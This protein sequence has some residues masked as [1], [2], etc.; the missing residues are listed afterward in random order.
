MIV[1]R[2]LMVWRGHSCPRNAIAK[3]EHAGTAALESLL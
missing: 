1:W 2:Q 3:T